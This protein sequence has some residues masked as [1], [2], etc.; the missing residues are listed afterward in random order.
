MTRLAVMSFGALVLA[1]AAVAGLDAVTVP[2]LSQG[3][4]G[5]CHGHS[6]LGRRAPCE[7][8]GW[9]TAEVRPQLLDYQQGWL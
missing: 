9:N 1:L 7:T 3:R 6:T 5:G 4:P 2:H 8:H